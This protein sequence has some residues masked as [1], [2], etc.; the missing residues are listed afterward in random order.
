MLGPQ[1]VELFAKE[2]EVIL[3]G[4]VSLGTGFEV[5]K[6]HIFLVSSLSVYLS[7]C[8]CLS[9]CLCLMLVDHNVA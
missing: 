2:K 1:L 4:G 6:A 7:L 3:G 8:V 9:V 5:P